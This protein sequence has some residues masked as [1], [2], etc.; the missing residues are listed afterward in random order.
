[1]KFMVSRR[2]IW[3]TKR[4]HCFALWNGSSLQLKLKNLSRRERTAQFIRKT[5]ASSVR[6]KLARPEKSVI[7]GETS[8]KDN[9][10]AEKYARR[11]KKRA[12][13]LI[14]AYQRQN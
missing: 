11:Q 6:K 7:D 5:K 1:M 2:D 9:E 10:N 13:N 3:I 14:T 8:K 4:V 12:N